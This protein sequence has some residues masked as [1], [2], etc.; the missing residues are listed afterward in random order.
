MLIDPQALHSAARPRK[1][2][3]DAARMVAALLLASGGAAQAQSLAELYDAAKAH[4]AGYQSAHAQ[5]QASLARA[6]QARAGVLPSANL[7]AAAS[8]THLDN[9]TLAESPTNPREYGTQSAGINLSQPLY[10]PANLASYRQGEQQA[11]LAQEQLKAA[12]QDLIV[13]LTQGYFDVLG[14][15]DSL[16]FVRAQKAAVA[17]QLAAAKRN[18]EVGTATITDTREAQA[19]F[20]LV[21]AQEIAAENELRVKQLALDNLTGRSGAAPWPLKPGAAIPEPTPAGIEHWVASAENESPLIRQARIALEVAKLEVDKAK[22]GEKPTLDAVAG[23]N[24]TLNN[25]S[26]ANSNVSHLNAASIS[27]NLNLPLFAGFALQN[28]IKET[29]ALEDKARADLDNASRSATQAV[30]VAYLGVLSGQGQVKAYQA[31][32]ASSQSALDASRLGYQVGVR[33]NLDVLNAQSQLFDTKARL[34]K[35]RYELLV[36]GLKLRQAGGVLKGEDVQALNSLI[37]L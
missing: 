13:R 1:R 30:R 34:A 2:V 19:R 24:R 12:E 8:R 6:A 33:I 22:A 3:A 14:A 23:I 7:T 26:N 4:D 32:E 37:G 20:D 5:Y 18:F 11:L 10:R 36:G 16:A 29:L 35:A 28:R 21:T 17:E 15:Q 27:L 25:G 9:T 31:A